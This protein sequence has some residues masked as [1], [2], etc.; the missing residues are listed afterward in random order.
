MLK[1]RYSGFSLV[2]LMV[3]VA[4]IGIITAIALPSYRGYIRDSFHAQAVA[5]MEVCA[6]N[7]E[8]HYSNG[9]IGFTYADADDEGVCV[10]WSPS[11]GAEADAQ[12]DLTYVTNTTTDW[13]IQ[14][15]PVS[16]TCDG[17]CASLERNGTR[18]TGDL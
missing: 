15:T 2:E 8:R 10:L 1:I 16:G 17:Y 7:L 3:S 6:L 14:M 5:D 18:E 13:K 11:D 12:Y 4:I 9:P